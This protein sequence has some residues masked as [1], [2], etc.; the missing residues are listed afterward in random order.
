VWQHPGG[1]W[2]DWASLGGILAGDPTV[3]YN[4]DG[5]LEV[6]ARAE[7]NTVWHTWQTTPGGSWSGWSSHG[8][9][10]VS[11][12]AV[13]TN[14]DGRLEVFARAPDDTAF[15]VWQTTAGGSWSGWSSMGYSMLSHDTPTA[16]ENLDGRIEV[17][18][19]GTD[20]KLYVTVH[21][22][23]RRIAAVGPFPTLWDRSSLAV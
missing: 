5:R 13:G 6:A 3:A 9:A 10:V 1:G 4:E 19:L 11:D 14:K 2:S 18:L 12:L 20:A 22:R 8:G 23:D 16:T 17:F 15:H 21:A 7:D